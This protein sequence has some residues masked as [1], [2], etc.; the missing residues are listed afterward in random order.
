MSNDDF[1]SGCDNRLEHK[2]IHTKRIKENP[3]GTPFIRKKKKPA[4]AP[5]NHLLVIREMAS[6]D[7][8][9]ARLDDL[10]TYIGELRD[11]DKI[12][13][14]TLEILKPVLTGQR[15][16]EVE[17]VTREAKALYDD[18]RA[19]QKLINS[20]PDMT[21]GT[22]IKKPMNVLKQLIETMQEV[23]SDERA[24]TTTN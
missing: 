17:K 10:S 4:K 9:L 15:L 6:L 19:L 16:F 13:S 11:Q 23:I 20:N 3:D 1:F 2:Q 5:S 12:H 8:D 24:N 21:K 22:G 18:A 7:V 14:K